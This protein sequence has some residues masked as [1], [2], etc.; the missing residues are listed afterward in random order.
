[1]GDTCPK[2]STIVPSFFEV[3]GEIIKENTHEDDSE[4]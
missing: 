2:L 4:T 3:I 1:M